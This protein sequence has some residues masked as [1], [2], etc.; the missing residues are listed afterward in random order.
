MVHCLNF[1]LACMTSSR[2]S[3]DHISLN[4]KCTVVILYQLLYVLVYPK[5][6][7]FY[8]KTVVYF[9]S[10]VI[11]PKLGLKPSNFCCSSK[12]LHRYRANIGKEH[13][14]STVGNDYYLIYS[15]YFCP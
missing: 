5:N 4:C 12:V 7:I 3:E 2:H 8:K 10:F 1:V 14:T 6:A 9:N 15:K 11:F 13:T